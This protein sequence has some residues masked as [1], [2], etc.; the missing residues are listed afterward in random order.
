MLVEPR[1]GVVGAVPKVQ[2]NL[3]TVTINYDLRKTAD[4][5]DFCTTNLS[6][7]RIHTELLAV[8]FCGVNSKLVGGFV[9]VWEA[10]LKAIL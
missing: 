3:K 6:C 10:D 9:T 4:Q 2:G 8:Q 1:Q 5:F 7:V